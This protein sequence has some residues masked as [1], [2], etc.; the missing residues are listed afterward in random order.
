MVP[1][2]NIYEI[3]HYPSRPIEKKYV[4]G[5]S[6]VNDV[7]KNARLSSFTVRNTKTYLISNDTNLLPFVENVNNYIV[8]FLL[9]LPCA[10]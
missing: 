1:F 2:Q 4:Y 7:E 10:Y 8:L 3:S 5:S 9:T 6:M